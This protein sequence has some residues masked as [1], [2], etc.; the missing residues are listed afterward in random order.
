MHQ[1]FRRV[2]QTKKRGMLIAGVVLLHDNA[3]PHNSS[4][5]SS[6]FNGIWLAVIYYP[7]YGPDFAPR[8]FHVFSQLKKFRST[9]E[10]FA[11]DED[12]KTSVTYWFHSQAAEFYD[13]GIQKL[14]PKYD[15]YLNSG[16]GYVE[17]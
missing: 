13:R 16:G 12:L 7:P 1:K 6:C 10:N 4:T 9:A 8:D 17:K 11:I 5:H 15:K 3:R 14:I 2:I